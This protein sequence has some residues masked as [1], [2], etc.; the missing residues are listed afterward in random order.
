MGIVITHAITISLAIFH[1]TAVTRFAAPTPIIAPVIVW[2]V[3]TGT[4]KAVARKSV[5]APPVSAQNQ[6]GRA[7]V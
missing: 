2:V 3:D 6:I 5:I 4:P 1:L 7:H